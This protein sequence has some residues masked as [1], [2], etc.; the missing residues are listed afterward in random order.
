MARGRRTDPAAA[1]LAKV[2]HEMGF[3]LRL[4]STASGLP[5]GTVKD[6]IEGNG[7]WRH[8]PRNEL[9]EITRLR[10]LRAIDESLYDLG[11]EAI[12]KLEERMKTAS[13]TE[14]LGIVDVAL[15][16]GDTWR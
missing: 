2:L 1:V 7:P 5:R 13:F 3:E 15:N 4:I 11:M 10:L 14:L 16:R 6:I 12:A 8:V 9:F